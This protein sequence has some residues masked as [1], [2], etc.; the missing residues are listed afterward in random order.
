[1]IS[2][3]TA[4]RVLDRIKPVREGQ[5]RCVVRLPDGS[6]KKKFGVRGMRRTQLSGLTTP[7]SL[8]CHHSGCFSLLCCQPKAFRTSS[9][10][11]RSKPPLSSLQGLRPHRG[12]TRHNSSRRRRLATDPLPPNRLLLRSQR[13]ATPASLAHQ[14]LSNFS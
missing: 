8:H 4:V 1:M 9:S 14:T 11:K 10:P 13:A 2:S 3:C 5:C 12:R 6:R 7:F